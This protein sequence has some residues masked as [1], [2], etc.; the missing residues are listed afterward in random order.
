MIEIFDEFPDII[1]KWE[2]I[3]YD[4]EGNSFRFIAKVEFIDKSILIIKEYF[5]ESDLKRKYSF[6]WMDQEQNLL[7]RWDNSN[8]WS[9]LNTFPHHVHNGVTNEVNESRI[10]TLED[11]LNFIKE[12]LNT[13]DKNK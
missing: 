13:D 11:I 8:H 1:S 7:F 6:H 4:V 2:V 5:Y 12:K 3:K 9:T 10:T